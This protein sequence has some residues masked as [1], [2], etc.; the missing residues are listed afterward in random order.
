MPEKIENLPSPFLNPQELRMAAPISKAVRP[1]STPHLDLD[2][3]PLADKDFQINDTYF[4]ETPIKLY[5]RYRYHYLN[6]TDKIG[7]W[8]SNFPRYQFLEVHIF[9]E[10]VCYCHAE[11][12]PSQGEIMSP[13]Q[14]ILFTIAIESIHE[15]LQLQQ[16]QNLTP[17][18]IRDLL[19]NFP[20][21][22]IA[23]LAKM[24]QTFIREEKHIRKDPPPYV[25]TTFFPFGQDIIAMICSVLGYTTSEY[26]DEIILAFISIFNPRKPPT[27]MYDYAKYTTNRMH[28]QFLR[29]SNERVFKYSS[30]LY[31]LFLY[32]QADK[33]PFTLKKLD[34]K[35]HHRLVIF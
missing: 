34:I 30:V 6:H 24:F 16:E 32:Y 12:I 5:C 29:M 20:K 33:L 8:E 25:A 28:E 22:T 2:H 18:S 26:I 11:Y 1:I 19:D 10:I 23:K 31:H 17:I 7:L 27:V 9:P 35:G 13:D 21:L 4:L 14:T 15:M 3:L